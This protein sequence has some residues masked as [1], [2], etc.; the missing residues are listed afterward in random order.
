MGIAYYLGFMGYFM[1]IEYYGDIVI[2]IEVF[3]YLKNGIF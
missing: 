2:C 3:S 1:I